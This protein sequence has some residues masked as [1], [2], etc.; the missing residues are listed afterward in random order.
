MIYRLLS[1]A[2]LFLPYVACMCNLNRRVCAFHEGASSLRAMMLDRAVHG[3]FDYFAS[4]HRWPNG[5]RL[6]M[7][8]GSQAAVPTFESAYFHKKTYYPHACAALI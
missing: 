3:G 6:H 4:V 7:C 5:T 2:L 1:K 8:D